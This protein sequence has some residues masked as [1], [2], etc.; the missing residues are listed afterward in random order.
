[1]DRHVT[2]REIG[3][4]LNKPK[5][6]AHYHI[7]SLGLVKKLDI[8]VPHVLKEIHLTNRINACDMQLKR[9]EFD[10]FLKRIITGDEKW[11]VYNNVSRKRSWSKHGEPA[12]T[13]SRADIHQKK[14]MLSVW[15]DWKGVV[16]FEL[17]PGNP[18]INSD[19]YC[20]QLDKLKTAIKAVTRIGLS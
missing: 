4:K 20:Q 14:V 2:E 15:W 19:V 10:P 5:S 7:K 16:Y 1:M 17:L 6:T 3:E 8:W 13:T 12:Q 18:M 9:N 11:I